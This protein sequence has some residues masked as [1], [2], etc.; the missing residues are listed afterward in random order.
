MGERL[1]LIIMIDALGH[2]LVSEN[3]SFG[4]LSAPEGPVQSVCGYSSACIPSLLT[5]RLPASHGHWGMYLRDPVRSVFRP[6]RPMIAL[7]AG[8]L[9]REWLTRRLIT[10]GLQRRGIRGYF[11]LYE[12]PARLLPE[13]N[14]CQLRD[15]FAPQ[16][17]ASLETPFDVVHQLG[18]PY[19]AWGWRTPEEENRTQLRQAIRAGSASMLFF[20]SPLLDAVMHKHGTRSAETRA[21]LADFTAFTRGCLKDAQASYREVHLL[22]FGDHGMADV[23][24]VHDLLTPIEAL[25]A[26]VPRDMLYFVDSTMARFWFF[27]DGWREKV[28]ALLGECGAGRV[29]D[30][31]ECR[32][33]GV[34]YAD[35]RYGEL[36]YLADP[37]K[38]LVPS[39][40]GVTAPKAMHGYHPEDVDS[41]TL[42][43]GNFDRPQVKTIMEIGPLLGAELREIAGSR[44]AGEGA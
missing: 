8:L 1:L 24:G 19:R 34:Y 6:Y 15:L 21:C 43:L 31:E 16:A 10:R 9:R 17:F 12:I 11:C 39:F 13:F 30:D 32:R 27:R 36:V 4:F 35:H 44:G 18:L 22:V 37:G 28:T 26:R 41:D 7:T 42:L 5:G 38:I 3:D 29:L 23:T 33:L 14:L 25:G 40:M 2:R 20:Y